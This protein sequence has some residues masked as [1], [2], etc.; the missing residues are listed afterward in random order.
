MKR[1]LWP[2]YIALLTILLPH[3]AWTF[4]KFEPPTLLG[5]ITAWAA[6][7][8]FEL[9]IAALTDRMTKQIEKTP[10]Y[11]TGRVWLRKAGFRY[12]N[13]Y[14]AGLLISLAVSS[15]A[16]FAHAVEFAQPLAIFND[17]SVHPLLYSVAFGGILP[18]VSLLFAGVL[19]KTAPEPSTHPE[20]QTAKAAEREAKRNLKKVQSLLDQTN[21][22]LDT[23][24][25]LFSKLTSDEK[26]VRIEF[27]H[28][29]WPNLP[30]SSIAILTDAS[31]SYVSEILSTR[32]KQNDAQ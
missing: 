11:T 26:R 6:A 5:E 3:T 20:I 4:K 2:I 1:F 9:A 30:A 10:N 16:N 28:T 13:V 27:T 7:I 31:P 8:A 22:R 15:L 24:G 18:V 23:A 21:I 14:F 12:G 25:N 19:S 32:H 29:Q 17:H